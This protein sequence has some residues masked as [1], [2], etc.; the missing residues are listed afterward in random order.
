MWEKYLI[1]ATAFGISEKVVNAIK[2]HPI[3][4]NIDDSLILNR[5]SY[6]HSRRR[7]R[8]SRFFGRSIHVNSRGGGFGGSG[9][10]GGGRRR[11]RWWRRPLI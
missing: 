9:Y 8:L 3:K 11:R 5:R 1:Y 2:I 10:R 4:S 6:I 7:R